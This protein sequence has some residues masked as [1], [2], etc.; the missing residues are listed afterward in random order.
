MASQDEIDKVLHIAKEIAQEYA[1]QSYG[2][3]H[4]LKASLHK[5][6]PLLRFLHA[7]DVDVYFVDEWAEV[8]IE[9]FPK[10]TNAT[11]EIAA[12]EEAM[13]VIEEADFIKDKLQKEDT[14]LLCYF[15]AAITPGIG[16]SYDQLKSLPVL[17]T[18]L[19]EQ[20]KTGKKVQ[21]AADNDSAQLNTTNPAN[22]EVLKKYTKDK[23]ASAKADA[24]TNIIGRDREL[25]KISE[26]LSRKSKPNVIV[27]GEPGVGKSALIGNLAMEIA[28][29][30]IVASLQDAHIV[31]V[32]TSALL[33]GASYKGEIEDRLQSIFTE[34]KGYDKPIVFIDDIH[35]LLEDKT[36]SQSIANVIK[37]ELNKGEVTLIGATTS[38]HY[39]K[40]IASDDALNRRFEAVLLEEPDKD[41]AFRILK[42]V[43][44]VYTEHHQLEI[45]DD[46]LKDVVRMAKAIFEG[47]KPA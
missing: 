29:Q 13:I 21:T 1:Q 3:A 26:I 36:T 43:A 32:D 8:H 33:S 10:R 38:D 2:P 7:N 14:D 47:K 11:R 31:E 41:L 23:I 45:S 40:Y 44:P 25:K 12:N 17:H 9:N 28:E 27:Q 30:K 4:I 19:L 6:L 16:F 22:S 37:A 15:I 18:Q 20:F 34:V 39:R 42:K 35:V 24:Y 5:D 46:T